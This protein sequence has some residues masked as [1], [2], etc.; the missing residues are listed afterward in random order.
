MCLVLKLRNSRFYRNNWAK[1]LV[2]VLHMVASTGA[3]VTLIV[4]CEKILRY[5]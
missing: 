5:I 3:R 2:E 1:R 4:V